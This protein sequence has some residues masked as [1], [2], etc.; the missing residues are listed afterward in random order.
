MLLTLTDDDEAASEK[1]RRVSSWLPASG[2]EKPGLFGARKN[3]HEM[4]S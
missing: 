4:E 2:D 3:I 1:G